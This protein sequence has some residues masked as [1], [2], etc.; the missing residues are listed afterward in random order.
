[1]AR[2]NR[3]S[4]GLRWYPRSWRDQYGDEFVAFLHD[5]YGDGSIP[6]SARVS[7]LRS[8]TVERLRAGGVIGT[9]VDPDRRIR[10]ASLLVLCAWGVFV[11]VGSAFAKYT[12]HWPMSTPPVDQRLPAVAMGVVQGAAATGVLIL[13]VAGLVTLPS[14]LELVR[15]DGWSSLWGT[16]RAALVSLA[17]AGVAT[18]VVVAWNHQLGPSQSAAAPWALKAVGVVGGLLVVGALA[19]CAGTLVAVVHRL[20]LSH[21][22]TRALGLLAVAMAGVLNLIFVGALTWW[23]ATAIHAPWFFGSLVPGTS[24][25]PA[26]LAMVI[27]VVIMLG[28]LVLAGLGTLRIVGDLASSGDQAMGARP[29][30]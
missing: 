12:E 17:V 26:P 23:I 11:V 8:G 19:V 4:R 14:F 25:S 7:M 2:S 30:G 21:Q 10:G 22:A 20:R 6:L 13:V 1:M 9:S 18:V 27:L 5:R 15:S 29:T 3:Y 16:A 24:S 28:G